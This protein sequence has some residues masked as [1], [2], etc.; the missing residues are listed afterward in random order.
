[1]LNDIESLLN[2]DSEIQEIETKRANL[3]KQLS[4]AQQNILTDTKRTSLYEIAKIAQEAKNIEDINRLRSQYG[5]LKVFDEMETQFKE[6]LLVEEKLVELDNLKSE[7]DSLSDKDIK[8]LSIYNITILHGNLKEIFESYVLI[9]NP[10]LTLSLDRFDRNVVSRYAEHIATDFNQELLN[11]KWDMGSFAMSDSE[12]IEKLKK[13]SSLLFKLTKLYFNGENLVLW[14]FMSIANNFK[15]RF[16]YHFHDITSAINLYFKFLSDYLKNNLYK[17]ISIFEDESNGVSKQLIHEEFIDHVLIPIRERVN[18]TLLQ[19][20]IKTFIALISQIISTDKNLIS[21][22]QYRGKGL[23]SL[24]SDQSWEKWLQYEVA[25]ARKQFDT[26][27]NSPKYLFNSAPNFNKLFK[28]LYEYLESFYE[29]DYPSLK[30]FKLRTCSQIFLQLS[31]EYLDFVMTTDSLD[32]KHTKEEE[33]FQTMMKLQNLNIAYNN[34]YELS[35]HFIFNELTEIVNQNESKRYVTIFQDILKAY[36]NDMEDDLQNSI[37]HR[38]QKLIKESLQNY[39]KVNN[40]I[41]TETVNENQYTPTAEVVN[42]IGMLK[43]TVTNL[44]SLNIPYHLCLNIKNEILNRVVNYFI[45]SILK[46]NKFNEQGLLQFKTDYDFVKDVL[47]IP[48][49]FGNCQDLVLYELIKLLCLKYDTD[50]EKYINKEFVKNGEFND[51]K[52]DL[53]LKLL[54]DSEIQDALYRI[55]LGNIV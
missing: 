48:E 18:S 37:I 47:N 14:N 17:C 49:N 3:A 28:K 38:I 52:K 13:T 19:N 32:E 41:L 26:I 22:F 8:E 7:L 9:D 15:I 55:L 10:L 40:W 23:A 2:I 6:E 30:K 44:D 43:R 45:E 51:L 11:S 42:C 24:V 25:T 46:L 33:L 36:Q 34:I 53:S 31:S 4:I 12:T 5:H 29:L 1:M 20:D 39:F 27:T 35:Q 21:E 16:T 54:K 50:L